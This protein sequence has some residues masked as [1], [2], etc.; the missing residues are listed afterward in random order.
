[1]RPD[2]PKPL[3]RVVLLMIAMLAIPAALTLR[4]VLVPGITLIPSDDPT[5]Y[6]YTWSLLLFIFPLA[7]IAWWFIRHPRFT[8]QRKAYW[9]TIGI[10]APMGFA[11]DILLGHTFFE[12]PNPG[13]TL[14]LAVPGV[15]G[16]IPIEEFVFYLSGFLFILLFYIWNDEF[17][18]EAYN[19]P[20]YAAATRDSGPILSFH[21][22]SVVLGAALLIA[23]IVYK[24]VLA[25]DPAGFPLYF[26]FLLAV[27]FV[28]AAGLFRSVRPFINWR[29]FSLTSFFVV[30]ISL[31]WEVTLALPYGWWTFQPRMMMGL[32]IG[33]WSNLPIEEVFLW[34]VV[35]F[36]TVVV[37][38]TLKIWLASGKGFVE[39]MTG[40]RSAR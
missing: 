28:P 9:M 17:W 38:E 6:G 18:L 30:L 33:A 21:A 7:V 15:G 39:A 12:F 37:F 26:A 3:A 20:D 1:M 5:P 34:F 2:P 10:L 23:A 35:T 27:A 14:G 25:A 31:L 16:P 24:K 32:T 29:A 11:L 13:A 4:T 8:F 22:G 40:R 36:T 19:V